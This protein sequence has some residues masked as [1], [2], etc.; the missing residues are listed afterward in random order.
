MVELLLTLWSDMT[1]A[2]ACAMMMAVAWKNDEVFVQIMC[3]RA[4][5]VLYL[6]INPYH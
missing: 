1:I 3:K 4:A 2:V 6:K 5:Q